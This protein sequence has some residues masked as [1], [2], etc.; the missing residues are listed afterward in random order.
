MKNTWTDDIGQDTVYFAA[1]PTSWSHNKIGRQWLEIVFDK[2][3]KGKT[4]NC[5]YRLLLVNGHCSHVNLNFFD[6]A[7]KHQITVLVLPPHVTHRLQ[8]L[9]VGLFSPLSKAYSR[10]LSNYFAKGQGLVSMS[11][12]LFYLFFK[13]ALE[14][15]FTESNTEA[16]W[17]ATGIW[18]Y[19][20]DK[21]LAI[22]AKKRPSTLT[23]KLHIRFAPKT[24]L[25]CHAIWQL[26]RQ[27]DLDAKDTYIQAMLQG[28]EKLAAKVDVLEFENKGLIEALKVEKQKRNRGKRLNLLGEEDNGPLLFSPSYVRAAK[29]FAAKKKAEKEQHRK[30]IE[31]KKEEQQ[32]KK[33]QEE[34]E[35]K[36]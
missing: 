13:K 10:E 19:D 9:E 7:D 16:V 23:K 1:T 34:I 14:A 32:K 29:E 25:S 12:W 20:P 18:Q 31:K 30:N 17:W 4:G 35:K 27:G 11:K 26:A 28:S 8:P 3:T 22:C 33:V 2:Y 21:T 6:Y 15:S 5:G 36:A 24:P